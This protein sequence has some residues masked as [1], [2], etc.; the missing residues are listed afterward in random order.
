MESEWHTRRDFIRD[1]VAWYPS[2][3]FSLYCI[4]IQLQMVLHLWGLDVPTPTLYNSILF[5]KSYGSIF[6]QTSVAIR[7]NNC[8]QCM[9]ISYM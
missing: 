9:F 8:E 1:R 2:C 7:D 3:Y 6:N 5:G 4:I